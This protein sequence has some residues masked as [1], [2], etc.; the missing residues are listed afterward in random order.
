MRA[1]PEVLLE[2]GDGPSA[3]ACTSAEGT[4]RIL[5]LGVLADGGAY[6]GPAPPPADAP[7]SASRVPGRR[8]AAGSR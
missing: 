1:G 5:L 8:G 2:K 3:S 6:Q 4:E 7:V